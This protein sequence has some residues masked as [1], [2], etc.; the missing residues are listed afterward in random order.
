MTEPAKR[1]P[2]PDCKCCLECSETRC[3]LCRQPVCK[4]TG[5]KLSMAEQIRLYELTNAQAAERS[6]EGAD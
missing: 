1:H 5:R 2:C 3:R 4:S 6:P